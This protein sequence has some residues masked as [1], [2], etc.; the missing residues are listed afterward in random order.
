ML[1]ITLHFIDFILSNCKNKNCLVSKLYLL[2][3]TFR[4]PFNA[5]FITDY[6]STPTEV[7]TLTYKYN[8]LD[9]S[10]CYNK[11][12]SIII[13]A[14]LIYYKYHNKKDFKTEISTLI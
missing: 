10:S 3:V 6:G 8:V 14:G 5:S 7:S 13:S 9:C 11:E 2:L 12:A 1:Q 4:E